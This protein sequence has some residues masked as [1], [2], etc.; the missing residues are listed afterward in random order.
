MANDGATPIPVWGIEVGGGCLRAVRAV[1]RD[2]GGY[3]ILAFEEVSDATPG[4]DALISFIRRKGL[5]NHPLVIAISSPTA[6]LLCSRLP[7][8]SVGMDDE[9]TR[10][11]LLEFIHQEPEDVEFRHLDLGGY[12]YLL[13][14]ENRIRVEGYIAALEGAGIPAYALTTSL[15]TMLRVLRDHGYFPGDG[16]IIRV[17]RNWSDVILLDGEVIEHQGLPVGSTHLVTEE[18]RRSLAADLS[19]LVE[20]HH[21]RKHLG[22][23]EAGEAPAARFLLL[24]L[25]PET[26]AA[27]T[28]HLPGEVVALDIQDSPIRGSGRIDQI[29]LHGILTLA[30]GAT[31]AAIA[32]TA[33]PRRLEL[34]FRPLPETI[35]VPRGPVALW[36]GAAALLL[37]AVAISFLGITAQR[38]ELRDALERLQQPRIIHPAPVDIARLE[39]LSRA[40]SRRLALPTATKTILGVLPGP[41]AAPYSTDRL[42]LLGREDGGFDAHLA[43]QFND[44]AANI[45]SSRIAAW[46]ASLDEKLP[47]GHQVEPREG[48][49]VV[50][51]RFEIEGE[52]P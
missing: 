34:A 14:A 46:L 26:A 49:V 39:S 41:D 20:Y 17:D 44:V 50:H 13:S 23:E 15:E 24:G 3:E 30:P 38:Q 43:L 1:R 27:I 36:L 8:E 19:K 4:P 6:R 11:E 21:H 48:G 18:A 25:P 33:I 22:R 28:P 2:G 32:G 29:R 45:E 42:E 9:D 16:L 5:K 31:G 35:S 51:I 47:G 12:R 7:M 52:S 37:V 40:A 10:S